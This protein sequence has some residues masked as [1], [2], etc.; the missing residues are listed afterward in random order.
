MHDDVFASHDFADLHRADVV[1]VARRDCQEYFGEKLLPPTTGAPLA[2]RS[3]E[4][5]RSGEDVY[6]RESEMKEMAARGVR[7]ITL[8]QKKMKHAKRVRSRLA[9][10]DF[11]G[12]NG[13]PSRSFWF[14]ADGGG[15]RFSLAPIP[16]RRRRS[17]PSE[18]VIAGGESHR[19]DASIKT[20]M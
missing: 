7:L 15:L 10:F 20:G 12:A 16:I 3:S 9:G 17:L 14:G 1:A 8:L 4:F 19:A 11:V 6:Q 5:S 13:S 2:R 18:G